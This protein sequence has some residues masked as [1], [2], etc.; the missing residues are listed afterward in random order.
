MKIIN[1]KNLACPLPVIEAKKALQETDELEILVDN[2]I[3]TQNLKKLAEQLGYDYSVQKNDDTEYVV[4]IVKQRKSKKTT[5]E[6]NV[7]S[8]PSNEYTVV[9]NTDV[10]GKGDERF[11]QNLLKMFIYTLTEQSVL[12]KRILFYNLGVQFVTADSPVLE[13][14]QRLVE[15]G[16]EILAC[17]ACLDYYQLSEKVVIGEVTNMY[18]IIEIL[19]TDPKIIYP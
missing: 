4:R 15:G 9:I 14:L 2:E 19:R 10:L 12:P 18:R 7:S 8:T 16:T 17:G 6:P 11:S 13:D 3:A 1:A 5:N